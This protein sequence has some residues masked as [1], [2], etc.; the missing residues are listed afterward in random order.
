M[1][2]D[3]PAQARRPGIA[4]FADDDDLPIPTA[5]QRAAAKAK[6]EGLG[7]VSEKP[8]PSA[9]KPKAAS[10]NGK[11]LNFTANFHIRTRPEDRQRFDDFA[12]RLRIPK[13]EAMQRLLDLA[14]AQEAAL[15]AQGGK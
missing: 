8:A 5:E 3:K 11:V 7:F 9:A 1:T 10:A 13:G 14:E 6:G 2:T 12:Y 4:S 15:K